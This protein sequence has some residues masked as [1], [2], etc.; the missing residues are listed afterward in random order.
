[1]AVEKTNL[2]IR[3]GAWV[4]LLSMLVIHAKVIELADKSGSNVPYVFA[5]LVTVYAMV[6]IPI[7]FI[8]LYRRSEERWK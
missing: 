1:M 6:S 3:L 4:D 5:V 7:A 2:E 8:R